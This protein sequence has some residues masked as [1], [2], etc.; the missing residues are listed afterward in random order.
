MVETYAAGLAKAGAAVQA[1][2]FPGF[3]A[4]FLDAHSNLPPDQV[5]ERA[6]AWLKAEFGDPATGVASFTAPPP[7]A[8]LRLDGAVER[9]IRFG[10]ELQGVLCEPEVPLARAPAVLIL[11]TGGDPRAGIG[12]FAASAARRLA[13]AGVASLRFDF[14]GLGDSPMADGAV[15]CH[16]YET[17]REAEMAA[18]ISLLAERN[19][20]GVV[21]V[22]VCAGAYHAMRTAWHDPRVTGFYA[23][24]PVKLIWKPGDSLAFGRKDLGKAT[25]VY[26]KAMVEADTWKR[27]LQGRIDLVTIARTLGPRLWRRVSGLFDRQA[28]SPLAEMRAFARRGGRA[29]FLMG[30]DDASLDE[31]ETYFGPQGSALTR[32]PNMSVQIVQDVDHGLARSVS[33]RIAL[34]GLIAWLGLEGRSAKR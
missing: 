15:R 33:R 8:S 25:R 24:S 17:P 13:A 28:D 27:L 11:N 16:V 9:A 10:P 32:A 22:G 3:E 30:L 2:D 21:I 31:I 5:F 7:P 1:G 4:L 12:G 18:A 34:D 19:S 23:V 26:T 14:A 29:H 20:S 6:T